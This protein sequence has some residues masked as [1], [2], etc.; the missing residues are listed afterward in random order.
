[1][2]FLSCFLTRFDADDDRVHHG[3]NDAETTDADTSR[4]QIQGRGVPDRPC[5]RCRCG[6]GM[7]DPPSDWR[8]DPTSPRV[9][10]GPDASVGTPDF[11]MESDSVGDTNMLLLH[12]QYDRD[13]GDVHGGFRQET[14]RC[15][16][17]LTNVLTT[18]VTREHAPSPYVVVV[19]NGFHDQRAPRSPRSQVL[20]AFDQRIAQHAPPLDF[21]A[22][23]SHGEPYW[24]QFGFTVPNPGSGS[25]DLD[26]LVERMSQT[27]ASDV[28]MVIYGCSAGASPGTGHDGEHDREGVDG[29]AD[30]LRTRLIEAG[31][32]NCQIDAHQTV[33]HTTR[34]PRLRRFH[35]DGSGGV[36]IVQPRAA[37]GPDAPV[38][39]R[40][41]RELWERWSYS[42][43]YLDMRFRAPFLTKEA[44][45][46]WL[47][48][49]NNFP[50]QSGF[51]RP[52]PTT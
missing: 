34:N 1:M 31:L 42:I 44:I 5:F 30:K 9:A 12:C 32:G 25:H 49:E 22:F 46:Q 52:L 35:G 13:H 14:Y 33:A 39:D 40:R 15:A 16:C 48:D 10:R 47:S 36:W 20:K 38:A 21:V 11:V 29:L 7:A 2:P 41:G 26:P 24:L 4:G 18:V 37:M 51:N 27:C 43:H 6:H 50:A 28:R 17:Y 19:N 8:M 23:F 45:E 3:T